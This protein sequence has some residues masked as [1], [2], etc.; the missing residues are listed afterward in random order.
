MTSSEHSSTPE[1][2]L[3]FPAWQREYEAALSETDRFALFKR[4]EV[5]EAA[6]LLRRDVLGP[7]RQDDAER[8]AIKEALAK[9]KAIKKER[10]KFG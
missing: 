1:P 2:P 3:R 6:I 9:L 4:I 8:Q 5:A 10:L 7:T